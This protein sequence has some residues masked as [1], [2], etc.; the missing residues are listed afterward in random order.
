[1][2]FGVD[3]RGLNKIRIANC[4]R[5]PIMN[6]L[7]DCIRGARI[8]KTMDLKNGYYLIRVKTGDEWKIAFWCRY[9][10]YQIM[11]MLFALTNT[12]A[13][14]QDMGNHI[15]KDLLDEGVVVYIDDVLIYAETEEKYDL[16]VK[17]V[18]IGLAENDLVISPE[19]YI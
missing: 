10:L 18:L 17:E 8:F 9:G 6:K 16:L 19:K 11:V 7:Q 15:L 14:F 5:L 1:L 4:Y 3:N 2:R 12:P 13:T